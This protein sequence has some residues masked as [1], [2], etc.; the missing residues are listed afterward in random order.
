[1]RILLYVTLG[2]VLLLIFITLVT[3]L[4]KT[5][6]EKMLKNVHPIYLGRLNDDGND[7]IEAAIQ[8]LE[9]TNSLK[10]PNSSQ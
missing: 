2:I 8:Y 3:F 1:M 4:T 10:Y 6:A 5:T 7:S 9:L